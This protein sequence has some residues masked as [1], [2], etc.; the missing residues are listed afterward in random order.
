[1]KDFGKYILSL[2]LYLCIFVQGALAQTRILRSLSVADGLSGSIVYTF[3]K[4]STGY[5]WMGTENGLDRFDGVHFRHY[6]VPLN[7]AKIINAVVEMSGGEI[8][9]G[10]SS[11][12]WKVDN[13]KGDLQPVARDIINCS[14][15]ALLT[16]GKG[17]LY[18]ASTRGLY[19]YN[20]GQW[21]HILLDPN[22]LSDKN[23]IN[24]I[25]M[26]ESGLLWVATNKG[27]YSIRVKDLKVQDR[28]EPFSKANPCAFVSITCVGKDVFIGTDVKGLFKYNSITKQF[29]PFG[30]V[31]SPVI[32]SLSAD[33]KRHLLYVGTDGNGVHF[34]SADTGQDMYSLCYS[35]DRTNT[36]RSNSV[37]SLLV[38]RDGILWVGEYQTGVDYTLFQDGAFTLYSLPTV[39]DSYNLMVR[40]LAVHGSWRLIG[41]RDGLYFIDEAKRICRFYTTP[42]LKSKMILCCYYYEGKFYVGTFRGGVYELEPSTGNIRDFVAGQQSDSL[43]GIVFCITTA[44]DGSLWMG[45]SDGIYAYRNGRRT[46][47]Y[48]KDNSQLPGNNV[49]SIFFDKSGRGWIGTEQGLCIYDTSSRA[50]RPDVFP[51]SFF[52]KERIHNIYQDEK[53]KIYFSAATGTL[54]V[55]DTDMKQFG[56]FLPELFTDG[57]KCMFVAQDQ[58]RRLWLG[59]NNGLYRY[60]NNILHPYAFIDGVPNPLFLNCP[61]VLDETGR[62]WLGNSQGVVYYRKKASDVHFLPY[63]IRVTDVLMNG[64]SVGGEVIRRTETG[65]RL[66]VDIPKNGELTVCFS[67]FSYTQTA[68]LSYEYQLEGEDEDWKPLKGCSEI[69]WYNLSSGSYTLKI[70]WAGMPETMV[71]IP[72]RVGS[73]L[74][75]GLTAIFIVI[76]LIGGTTGMVY[77]WRKDGQ[78]LFRKVLAVIRNKPELQ[79]A[80]MNKEEE[81]YRTMKLSDE[82]CTA[83]KEKLE[84]LMQEKRPY[85]NPK[86]KLKDLAAMMN[87]PVH[88]LSYLFNMSMHL[89]YND[90]ISRFRIREFKTV[91]EREDASQ[92]TIEALA[93]RC[94]FSSKTSFFRNFKQQEG[95]TPSEYIRRNGMKEMAGSSHPE[96]KVRN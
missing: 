61:P 75:E 2:I 95:I 74:G 51:D 57:T 1:M 14:V 69:K 19:F 46:A 47:H 31:G 88:Q 24:S 91:V 22:Q 49:L 73:S 43:N 66:Q 54:Y 86:L 34:L 78:F 68:S 38:D 3:Y 20:K 37:Y 96:D 7:A 76:V 26:G 60:D 53:G 50:L 63:K 65:D 17:G 89:R 23:Y 92:Y 67:N 85:L 82:E 93:E 70:R 29:S 94:G 58:E 45:T 13:D 62:L 72:F 12:L 36:L 6:N 87:T 5:V 30:D 56:T 77:Y 28:V 40:A 10:N 41:T 81:K 71:N 79:G 16:D 25:A 59:T 55:S 9:A 15:T 39:F 18:V 90:Y 8:W 48:A 27:F 4:D 32:K 64:V 42:Q 52:N 21:K 84:A 83:L 35:S 33:A 44:P 80:S 11:G